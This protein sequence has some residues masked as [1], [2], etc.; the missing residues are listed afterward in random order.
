MNE[1]NHL[2]ARK[3]VEYI[4]NIVPHNQYCIRDVCM[5]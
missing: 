2:F 3:H 4:I 5:S 1:L